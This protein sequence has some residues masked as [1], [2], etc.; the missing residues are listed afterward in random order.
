M[1]LTGSLP[2]CSCP[3]CSFLLSTR[4]WPLSKTPPLLFLHTSVAS[5]SL[6]HHSSPSA[7]CLLLSRFMPITLLLLVTEDGLSLLLDFYVSRRMSLF[8]LSKCSCISVYEHLC[9]GIVSLIRRGM[10]VRVPVSIICLCMD[11]HL[12]VYLH[13]CTHVVL[14]CIIH[15][16]R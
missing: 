4:R 8:L 15:L 12:H 10:D 13:V 6:A 3:A 2:R 5:Y 16:C 14:R 11:V 1:L 9:E 7:S